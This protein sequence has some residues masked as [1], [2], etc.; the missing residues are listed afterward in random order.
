VKHPEGCTEWSCIR[1]CGGRFW[2]RKGASGK[3]LASMGWQARPCAN[4]A[5]FDPAKLP[6]EAAAEALQTG[7][8]DERD[9]I[10]KAGS[11]APDSI[12]VVN[13]NPRSLHATFYLDGL[14][15]AAWQYKHRRR[16]TA[17]LLLNRSRWSASI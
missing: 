11:P 2:R 15:L 1:E 13:F 14:C 5:A 12:F 17:V 9:V 4:A 8:V 3:S 16:A 6:A 7:A 10:P